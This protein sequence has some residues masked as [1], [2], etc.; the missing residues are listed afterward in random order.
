[1]VFFLFFCNSKLDVMKLKE[2]ITTKKKVN[3][4]LKKQQA[5]KE[6]MKN[7]DVEQERIKAEK[8][9]DNN[10]IKLFAEDCK[11]SNIMVCTK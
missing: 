2:L 6:Q 7:K 9:K 11:H 3:E 4:Q 8:S 10:Y 1:M 5:H